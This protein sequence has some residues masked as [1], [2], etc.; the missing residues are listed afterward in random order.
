VACRR[1]HDRRREA[2]PRTRSGDT[3]LHLAAEYGWPLHLGDGDCE[4][5][6]SDGFWEIGGLAGAKKL[7]PVCA[8]IV[9]AEGGDGSNDEATA[10]VLLRLL[11]ARADRKPVLERLSKAGVNLEGLEPRLRD[12]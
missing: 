9:E 6:E 5:G 4:R 1:S 8:K 11:D 12:W 2:D 10:A 3:P 7:D